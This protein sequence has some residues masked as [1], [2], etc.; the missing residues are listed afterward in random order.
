M[1]D[2]PRLVALTR[3]ISP[4]LERCELTH[5][6]RT[7]IDLARA[8]RQHAA[9]EAAL[10]ELGCLVRRLPADEAMPDSVFIEDVAVVLDEVAV[11]TRPGATSRRRETAVVVDALAPYRPLVRIDA[12]GTLDGG[13]V[14]VAGRTVFV[15]R[16]ARTNDDGIGQLRN[17]LTPFGYDVR[18]VA[19]TGCLHLKTAVTCVGDGRLLINREWT[20]A[21]A[22][23]GWERIDVDPAEPFAANGLRVGSSVIYPAGFPRTAD[24]LRAVGI[25]VVPV[26]ADELAKAEGAVTCCSL[27]F[28]A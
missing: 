2:A 16:S 11:I 9:Y 23:S 19:V 21:E 24:Q 7:R 17:E 10:A 26:P 27:V 6:A 1:T 28:R 8:R 22:F 20:A 5:L 13:D 25:D 15:G 18:A 3:E 14:L 12:P 4:A